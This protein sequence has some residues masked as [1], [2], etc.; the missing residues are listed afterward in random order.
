MASYK[1]RTVTLTKWQRCN[2]MV[3][4]NIRGGGV[5]F[6]ECLEQVVTVTDGVEA[7]ESVQGCRL[8]FNAAAEIPL[9]SPITGL[10]TGARMTQA[11]VYA[12]LYSVYRHAADLRDTPQ[13]GGA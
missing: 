5:P 12:I 3:I 8:A 6:V 10:L 2:R 1:S 9:R 4:E 13:S 7:S 11:E